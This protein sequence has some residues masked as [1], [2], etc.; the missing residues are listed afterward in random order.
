MAT[1][2]KQAAASAI[3]KN[4]DDKKNANLCNQN[5]LSIKSLIGDI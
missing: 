2:P 3:K 1:E 4:L 5:H